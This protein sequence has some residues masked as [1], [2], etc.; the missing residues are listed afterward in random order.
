MR[1]AGSWQQYQKQKRVI[2][3]NYNWTVFNVI[4]TLIFI[5]SIFYVSINFE[6]L[7]SS[8]DWGI[9]GMLGLLGIFGF[10]FL[11]FFVDYILQKLMT[12]KKQLNVLERIIFGTF[13]LPILLVYLKQLLK[14]FLL[15]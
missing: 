1:I 8:G 13:A 2:M 10:S 12:D 14:Y 5:I 4:S 3:K 7:L 9:L 11:V 6:N 15:N